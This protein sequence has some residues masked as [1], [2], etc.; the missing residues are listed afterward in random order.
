MDLGQL[1][2]LQSIPSNGISTHRED[3]EETLKWAVLERLPT[4]ERARK[5][6]LHGMA[7]GFKEIDLKNLGFQENKEILECVIKDIDQN[8]L[9]LKR[10][11]RR[12]DR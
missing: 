4:Y 7:G 1:R 9:Y 8:E 5:G 2:T 3:D 12:I 6:L 10:L 11:K